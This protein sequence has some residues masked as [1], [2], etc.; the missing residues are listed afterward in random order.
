[1]LNENVGVSQPSVN[2]PLLDALARGG[3][4]V[5][6][7]SFTYITEPTSLNENSSEMLG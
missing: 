6:H 2:A 7:S 4:H 3:I 5:Q 1:M